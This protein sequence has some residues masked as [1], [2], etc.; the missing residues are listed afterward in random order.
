MQTEL[1]KGTL[2]T[3]ILKLLQE[4]G[5]M[6][7]YELT[8]VVKERTKGRVVL[9]E[10]SLYPTLHKLLDEGFISVEEEYTGK[11]VRRYYSTTAAG[12]A[13]AAEQVNFVLQFFDMMEGLL[14]P[15]D[16]TPDVLPAKA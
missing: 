7:G 6:Y 3:L 13:K 10:G 15:A 1:L 16:V 12:Q 9:K 11:R 8:Q 14:L 2:S 5:R 4:N